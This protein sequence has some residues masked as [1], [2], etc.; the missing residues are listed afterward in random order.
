MLGRRMGMMSTAISELAFV[1]R[2]TR[3]A[4]FL[5]LHGCRQCLQRNPLSRV[6]SR[7]WKGQAFSGTVAT[8]A[9]PSS[10]GRRSFSNSGL[11]QSSE[12]APYCNYHVTGS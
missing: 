5:A 4:T 12:A 6:P 3:Q 1:A 8:L 11:F 9:G 2:C 10:A 7:P